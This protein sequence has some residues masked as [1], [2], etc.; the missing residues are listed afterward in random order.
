MASV[1]DVTD[2]LASTAPGQT[3]PGHNAK[4]TLSGTRAKP[5][6]YKLPEGEP[7]VMISY[8]QAWCSRDW[9]VMAEVL[10]SLA[11]RGWRHVWID[12]AVVTVDEQHAC[13]PPPA[14]PPRMRGRTV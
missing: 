4:G 14:P 10:R 1:A 8:Q 11:E 9:R 3:Q 13:A 12:V 7:F 6:R 5:A 2:W